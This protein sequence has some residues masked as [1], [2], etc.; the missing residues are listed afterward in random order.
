MQKFRLIEF[1]VKQGDDPQVR[2]DAFKTLFVARLSYDTTEKDLER[3][4]GRFGPIE[5]VRF[6][7][8]HILGSHI[9]S[10]IQIRIVTNTHEADDGVESKKKK[11]IHRG[12][13]FVVYEREKDMKGISTI[14]T[15]DLTSSMIRLSLFIIPLEKL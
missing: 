9:N 6:R 7:T 11:K 4:F 2:G 8:I 5:R 10:K 13:A 1:V 12:Y 15:P 14:S 3:E